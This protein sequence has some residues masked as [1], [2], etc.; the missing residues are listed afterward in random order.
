MALYYIKITFCSL[1]NTC[2]DF[3]LTFLPHQGQLGYYIKQY[4]TVIGYI[5]QYQSVIK[6]K[7]LCYA[8]FVITIILVNL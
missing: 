4:Q 8:S 2:N 3:T 1:K 6:P 5:N 7:S